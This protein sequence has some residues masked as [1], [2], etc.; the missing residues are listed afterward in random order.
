MLRNPLVVVKVENEIETPHRSD[1][2]RLEPAFTRHSSKYQSYAYLGQILVRSMQ[3]VRNF[4]ITY[5][6]LLIARLCFA[7]FGT[8]Y[9]HPDEYFQ[10]G[11]VTA[12]MSLGFCVLHQSDYRP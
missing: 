6:G 7:I 4:R 2:T 10:N 1:W 11:E 9:I 8:G 3:T 5:A 12:G